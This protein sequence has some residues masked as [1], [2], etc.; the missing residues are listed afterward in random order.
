MN[1]SVL[2]CI[3]TPKIEKDLSKPVDLY[4]VVKDSLLNQLTLPFC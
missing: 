4:V 3:H 1:A 2:G